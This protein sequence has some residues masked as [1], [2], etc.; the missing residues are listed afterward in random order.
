[1]SREI[2]M[3]DA[4]RLDEAR[5]EIHDDVPPDDTSAKSTPRSEMLV[6][7]SG[8]IFDAA[9]AATLDEI[10]GGEEGGSAADKA[11]AADALSAAGSS[12]NTPS[13]DMGDEQEE[14]PELAPLEFPIG[15]P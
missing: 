5:G 11:G 14:A 3:T 1:M 4:D 9:E 13:E 8:E 2:N 15:T 10:D 12:D 6:D 7:E